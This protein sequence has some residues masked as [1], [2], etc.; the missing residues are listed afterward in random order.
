MRV[1]HPHPN[2]P[3]ADRVMILCPTC[4]WRHP[5]R[6]PGALALV[7][8]RLDV[9]RV[10][11]ARLHRNPTRDRMTRK[12]KGRRQFFQVDGFAQLE[13]NSCGARPRSHSDT[14]RGRAEQGLAQGLDYVYL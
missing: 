11:V 10:V 13:C 6:R 1:V 7:D 5:D 4:R 8:F 9:D 2:G 3:K 14:L 12:L